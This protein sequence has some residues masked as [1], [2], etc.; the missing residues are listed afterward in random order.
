MWNMQN[1]AI[2]TMDG[3]SNYFSLKVVV[4]NSESVLIEVQNWSLLCIEL[5]GSLKLVMKRVRSRGSE[6]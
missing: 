2:L 4:S 1:V 3:M 5:K 6:S